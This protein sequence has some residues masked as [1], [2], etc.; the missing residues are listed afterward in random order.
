VLRQ[1]RGEALRITLLGGIAGSIGAVT[2][3]RLL[4]ERFYGVDPFDAAT[5]LAVAA[6]LAAV[7]LAAAHRPAVRAARV[8]PDQALRAE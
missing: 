7:T 5:Y 1:V 4:Q 6:V 2:L 3:A 8:H